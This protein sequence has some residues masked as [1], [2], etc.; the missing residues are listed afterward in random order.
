[1]DDK[2]LGS[3][4]IFAYASET[5]AA[6]ADQAITRLNTV[7]QTRDVVGGPRLPDREYLI[8]MAKCEID[9]ALEAPF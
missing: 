6:F 5:V 9:F 2:M 7:V 4:E 8:E 3:Y 1:M